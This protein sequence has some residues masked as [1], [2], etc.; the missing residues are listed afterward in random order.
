[1]YKFL[2]GLIDG[3]LG[4]ADLYML[5]NE[6][7]FAIYVML[8]MIFIFGFIYLSCAIISAIYKNYKM[9]KEF[10]NIK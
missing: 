5:G 2:M 9:N 8:F 7:G 3:M 4:K 1:M 10:K 6:V